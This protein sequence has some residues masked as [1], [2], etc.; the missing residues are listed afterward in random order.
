M[1]IRQVSHST[2]PNSCLGPL[3]CLLPPVSRPTPRPSLMSRRS[4]PFL[5]TR[6]AAG[7][8]PDPFQQEEGPLVGSR[9]DPAPLP[10]GPAL[11]ASSAREHDPAPHRPGTLR[12]VP[13]PGCGRRPHGRWGASPRRERVQEL[14]QVRHPGPR[15]RQGQVLRLWS[16]ILGRVLL[17]PPS[18][19]SCSGRCWPL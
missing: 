5:S 6:R 1:P 3:R 18:S 9:S 12:D 11:P 8:H 15:L 4:T 2:A 14:P 16:R 17:P 19:T 10:P 13:R 7:G